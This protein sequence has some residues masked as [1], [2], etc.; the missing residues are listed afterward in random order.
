M[1]SRRGESVPVDTGRKQR[2]APAFRLG[3]SGN[4]A[5]RPKGSRCKLSEAFLRAIYEDFRQHGAAVI[6]QV[7]REEP[8]QYLRIIVS[9]IPKALHVEAGDDLAD[10]SDEDLL[11]LLRRYLH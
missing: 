6:E 11:E 9:V 5:G 1:K 3:Q 7:R 8:V 10:I 4:P 2:G